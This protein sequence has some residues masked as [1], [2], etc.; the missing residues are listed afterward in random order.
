MHK[1]IPMYTPQVRAGMEQIIK[2]VAEGRRTKDDAILDI[3]E[4]MRENYIKADQIK[5][6]LVAF[7]DDFTKENRYL[8]YN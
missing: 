5:D 8:N 3:K 6:H 1:D 7:I 4:Y 2:D